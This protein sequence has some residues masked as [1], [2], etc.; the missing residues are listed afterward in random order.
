MNTCA[1]AKSSWQTKIL[2]N[3]FVTALFI[4]T[5]SFLLTNQC[6]VIRHGVFQLHEIDISVE[7]TAGNY[8]WYI[9][10]VWEAV[11]ICGPQ[12]SIVDTRCSVMKSLLYETTFTI[13]KYI[14]SDSP[15]IGTI[16]T[17]NRVLLSV[18]KHIMFLSSAYNNF[19]SF[20]ISV[21][22][23]IYV[24]TLQSTLHSK[25]FNILNNDPYILF[26]RCMQTGWV[27]WGNGKYKLVKW[28]L[29]SVGRV[30]CKPRDG[31]SISD[32]NV[33][34]GHGLCQS[35]SILFLFN[36]TYYWQSGRHGDIN[37]G[38]KVYQSFKFGLFD[39]LNT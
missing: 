11:S 23:P 33:H 25:I 6:C 32:T 13:S 19:I 20:D 24:C 14:E 17:S 21:A 35:V 7:R 10:I 9:I 2:V 27:I 8:F 4:F 12:S 37:N 26:L 36:R 38:K 16:A 31:L 39:I 28:P 18:L 29:V 3:I 1:R 15:Q 30:H 5:F 22:L 34:H